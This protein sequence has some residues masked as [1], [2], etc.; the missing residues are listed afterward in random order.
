[1]ERNDG[2]TEAMH[3]T[4]QVSD[5]VERRHRAESAALYM[6]GLDKPITMLGEVAEMY[7]VDAYDVE[8]EMKNVKL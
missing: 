6:V 2:W 3:D 5:E 1:M 7:D 4:M 8:Q